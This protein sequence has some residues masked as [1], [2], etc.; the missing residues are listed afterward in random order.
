MHAH[1]KE[2][3]SDDEVDTAEINGYE[4]NIDVIKGI[5]SAIELEMDIIRK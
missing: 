1:D 2:L 4:K 5:D 3:N